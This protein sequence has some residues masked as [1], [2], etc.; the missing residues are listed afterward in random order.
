MPVVAHWSIE[1]VFAGDP[2]S[3]TICI[4]EYYLRIK[5]GMHPVAL[6]NVSMG[7][8]P[9]HHQSVN[10]IDILMLCSWIR[11]DIFDNKF[12]PTCIWRDPYLSFITLFH[13]DDSLTLKLF[14]L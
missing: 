12:R 7:A 8:I 9:L 2:T 5:S 11:A 3:V 10:Y 4:L 1:V 14:I 6:F 13:K